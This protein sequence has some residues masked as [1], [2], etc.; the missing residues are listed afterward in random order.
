MSKPIDHV[1]GLCSCGCGTKINPGRLWRRGHGPHGKDEPKHPC[2]CGCGV[3][4]R[5]EYTKGHEMRAR[6]QAKVA[7]AEALVADGLANGTRQLCACGCGG[8]AILGRRYVR[9]H[10]PYTKPPKPC[11]CGCGAMVDPPYDFIRG[12]MQ[13]TDRFKEII[14]S[15]PTRIAHAIGLSKAH[16]FGM[17]GLNNKVAA[18]LKTIDVPQT[19]EREVPITGFIADFAWVSE[20][21]VL[22]AQGCRWHACP[23]CP[24]TWHDRDPE[25]IDKQ[26][27][28]DIKKRAALRK[29]GWRT[30]YVWEHE[31]T[32]G[33]KLTGLVAFFAKLKATTVLSP[34]T[35]ARPGRDDRAF[36]FQPQAFAILLAITIATTSCTS[37]AR[38][39]LAIER[40]A[41]LMQV[42]AT[43]QPPPRS[44][45]Q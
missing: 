45:H 7:A 24:K 18:I 4:T 31:I 33:D 43:N 5:K 39:F 25:Q 44:M 23:L 42:S 37:A 3:L 12:H 10:G 40:G 38:S 30:V 13:R 14:K 6:G 27:L 19:F 26:Q 41:P 16:A 22:E 35:R 9:G 1:P 21:V 36:A 29:F 8:L 2:K 32:A 17:N 11:G 28:H 20:K 34:V 15:E